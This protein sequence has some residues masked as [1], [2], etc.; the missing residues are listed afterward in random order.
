MQDHMPDLQSDWLS[1]R[2]QS[3]TSQQE[4]RSN[5]V[6]YKQPLKTHPTVRIYVYYR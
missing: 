1:E 4:A 5:S 6:H 2:Y 3:E